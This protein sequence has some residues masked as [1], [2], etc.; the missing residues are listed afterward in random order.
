M[1]NKFSLRKVII[2]D[3]ALILKWANDP[4][5]REGSFNS[6]IISKEEHHNWFILKLND[7]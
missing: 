7:V 3:E 5:V 4:L 6:S 1:D 2:E